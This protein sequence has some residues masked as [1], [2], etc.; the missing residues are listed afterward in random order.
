MKKY[1]YSTLLLFVLVVLSSCRTDQALFANGVYTGVF[2]LIGA[3]IGIIY[4]MKKI[5]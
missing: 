2:A 5:L 4:V 3:V 1:S